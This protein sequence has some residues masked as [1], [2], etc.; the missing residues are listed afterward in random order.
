[1]LPTGEYIDNCQHVTL[2]CCTNLADFYQRI[3]VSGS[4]RYYD[5]LAFGDSK[6]HRGAIRSFPLPAPLHVVP[7]FAAFSLLGWR[8]KRA[9]ARAMFR[10]IR[11]RGRPKFSGQTTMLEWLKQN[12]QTRN[13]IDHFW[14]VVLV[15]ALNEQL[16]RT[17]AAYGI[18][19]FWKA[20][21]SNRDAFGMGIPAVPLETLYD[22]VADRIKQGGGSVHTRCGAAQFRISN[23]RVDAVQLDDGN[24]MT[25]DYYVAAIPFDRLLKIVPATL[26][27]TDPFAK[28]AKLSVSPIT[29]VH[30]W[31]DRPVMMEPFLASVDQTIQWVFNKS[32][33]GVEYPA[34]QYLQIVISASH[35]LA[36]HSQQDIISLCRTELAALLPATGS[37]SLLRAVVIRENAATFSPGPGCDQ[38][39][40]DARTAIRNLFL[41][42]DWIQTGWPATMESAVRSGY[43]AAEAILESESKPVRVTRLELPVS[44]LARWLGW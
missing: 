42:G 23:E 24:A 18:A 15:S 34:G 26:A 12:R 2:R 17:D 28:I 25:A 13:A 1:L 37:A 30:L 3:G 44:R 32:A 27:K 33:L 22:S 21:L 36:M 7:S 20:F 29:S 43:Q 41:A 31:L 4:I 11:A 39:R 40:P 16:D 19:L 6:G 35:A 8:D 5:R 10:I 38:W 9:I 14:R